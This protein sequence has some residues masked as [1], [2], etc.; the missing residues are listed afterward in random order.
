[1]LFACVNAGKSSLL[2]FLVGEDILPVGVT[3]V[4][5][6][7]LAITHGL[8]RERHVWF[9]DA[10]P[11]VFGLGRLGE[12]AASR[13]NPDNAHHMTHIE[14]SLPAALL[15]GGVRLVDSPGYGALPEGACAEAAL[16][17]LPRCDLG[18]LL[19]DAGTTLTAQ[20]AAV[21]SGLLSSGADAAVLLTK[22]D[23]LSD[24]DAVDAL[25]YARSALKRSLDIDVPVNPMS[26]KDARAKYARRWIEDAF[27]PQLQRA[28]ATR[29]RVLRYRVTALR[30][31]VIAV[32]KRVLA[33]KGH[34]TE[35][36]R[37]GR[38]SRRSCVLHAT[39][40]SAHA[41]E[42]SRRRRSRPTSEP[43][44][45][46]AYNAAIILQTDPVVP[47]DLT[48]I[49][50]AAAK[51][52]WSAA[53]DAA[54]RELDRVRAELANGLAR[55]AAAVAVRASDDN[56]LVR[57]TAILAATAEVFVP[58]WRMTRRPVLAGARFAL[59]PILQR[60][61]RRCGAA[62]GIERVL[63]EHHR[64]LAV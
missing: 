34:A 31:D 3:P 45:G 43:V 19:L 14:L 8:R 25:V 55:A 46:A 56:E 21:V 15:G 13:Q 36:R 22:A 23:L 17:Y 41:L 35:S 32:L 2:N 49:L 51:S 4:S 12:F 1:M 50:V 63:L 24:G 16:A 5:V 10:A 33:A 28:R 47:N 20:D 52:A 6:V 37:A 39:S 62:A 57:S 48:P 44:T 59:E 18:L 40:S 38:R 61:L 58:P 64:H 27:M 54:V 42:S 26:V 30:D 11:Q 7:P 29:R 9:A 60:H 53:T